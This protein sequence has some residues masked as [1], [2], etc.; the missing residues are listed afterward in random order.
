MNLL[1]V[2]CG[3]SY[4]TVDRNT[5]RREN[6]S[7]AITIIENVDERRYF[8]LILVDLNPF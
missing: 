4:I 3:V 6:C 5:I 8:K 1:H 7:T 2:Y